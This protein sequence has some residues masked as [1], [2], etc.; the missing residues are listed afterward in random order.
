MRF[1]FGANDNYTSTYKYYT[2]SHNHRMRE[3]QFGVENGVVNWNVS[4]RLQTL[5]NTVCEGDLKTV[6]L[7]AWHGWNSVL[8][9][10]GT[11][12]LCRS[13][14]SASQYHYYTQA[15]CEDSVQ[16]R[17]Q[18]ALCSF[19]TTWGVH[20]RYQP[21]YS[22][23]DSHSAP[24]PTWKWL[25]VCIDNIVI[26]VLKYMCNYTIYCSPISKMVCCYVFSCLEHLNMWWATDCHLVRSY[27]S[28]GREESMAEWLLPTISQS[29]KYNTKMN[30][31]VKNIDSVL[32]NIWIYT[33]LKLK[34]CLTTWQARKK[35]I[36]NTIFFFFHLDVTSNS[37]VL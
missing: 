30:T 10:S 4:T 25:G 6:C 31:S 1:F 20:S 17:E 18:C 9:F 34:I 5:W 32:L 28:I 37:E 2:S 8:Q 22:K 21:P 11:L 13:W 19:P 33:G 14:Y 7:F 26:Q 12:V 23:L 27:C 16:G 35:E 24:R 29:F 15:A 3:F 36:P